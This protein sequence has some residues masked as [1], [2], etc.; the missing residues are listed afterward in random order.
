MLS[1][2][3]AR[4]LYFP[5]RQIL[6]TPA[7]VGLAHEDVHLTTGD[8]VAIHGWWIPHGDERAAVLFLHGNAGNVSHR[9]ESYEIY[10]RL[11]LSVLAIDYRGFG[12]SQG[13]PSEKGP[14]EDARAAWHWLERER[15][16]ERSRIVVMGRSLGGG[17]AAELALRVDPGA[18]VLESTF[19]SI[20]DMASKVLPIPGAH[21]LAMFRYDN[22]AKV[23]GIRAPKLIVHSPDDEVV[24]FAHGLR[25]HDA[26]LAP[27]TFLEIRGSHADGFVHSGQRYVDGLARFLDEAL[28]T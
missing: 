6:A 3:Q 21:R 22:F 11:G 12:R 25:L 26:A 7:D 15:R 20:P 27:S 16:R 18:V 23:Q 2:L 5:T 13:R 14:Y 24:P 10:H 8:G 1:R 19:T 4:L 9:L 28:A 17:V